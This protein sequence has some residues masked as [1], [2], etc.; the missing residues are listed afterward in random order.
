M[1]RIALALIS[2]LCG[3]ALAFAQEPSGKLPIIGWISPAT[4][5]SYQQSIAGSPGPRLLRE[6][7]AR[8]GLIDGKNMRLDK[9]RCTTG[10]QRRIA[11]WEHEDVLEAVQKRLDKN[12][13]AHAAA[14]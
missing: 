7:L 1:R 2:L 10:V 5:E 4:T 12:P 13:Q 3:T 9:Q 14:S 6:S 8:H 11:R